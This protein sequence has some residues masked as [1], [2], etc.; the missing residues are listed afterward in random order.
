MKKL[1][2]LFVLV[3]LV[4]GCATGTANIIKNQ[5]INLEG[6]KVG[7]V[8]VTGYEADTAE[9]KIAGE[10]LSRGADV[11]E[12]SQIISILKEQ[13]FQIGDRVD[14]ETAVKIGKIIGVR[15]VFIGSLS[16]PSVSYTANWKDNTWQNYIVIFTGRLIDVESGKIIMSG[17]ATGK[18]GYDNLAAIEAISNFF[19]GI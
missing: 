8:S 4:S 9:S 16:Q 13:D 15:V 12:R 18:R 3:M 6:L 14:N 17:S 19:K 1:T 7:I 10:F 5:S 2:Y 11:I